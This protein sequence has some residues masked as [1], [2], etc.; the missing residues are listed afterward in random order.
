MGARYALGKPAACHEKALVGAQVLFPHRTIPSLYPRHEHLPLGIPWAEE[1]GGGGKEPSHAGVAGKSQP[2]QRRADGRSDE[3]RL[4]GSQP[5]HMV[6]AEGLRFPPRGQL[7]DFAGRLGRTASSLTP[8]PPPRS[9]PASR[10]G[11]PPA[12][13]PP[14]AT[15]PGG[16]RVWRGGK[17]T[18][19]SPKRQPRPRTTPPPPVSPPRGPRDLRE[20]AGEVEGGAGDG[21]GRDGS[22][23]GGDVRAC[24][25]L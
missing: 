15:C 25:R 22:G 24:G 8:P 20:A 4:S 10:P 3:T 11:S 6:S 9:A 1:E 13:R 7:A 18:C 21:M 12:A 17:P 14:R 5:P 19:F 16:A 2:G 23:R